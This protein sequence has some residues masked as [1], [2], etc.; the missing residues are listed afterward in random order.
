MYIEP[1]TTI[2]LYSGIPFDNTYEHTLWFDDVTAQNTYFHGGTHPGRAKYTLANNSYQR[3]ERGKMRIEKC[4]DDIYDCNYLAFQNTNYG[5]KWFYAFIIS[6]EYIN[7]VTSEIVFEIDVMQTYLFDMTLEECFVER[8]HSETDEI[9]DNILPEPIDTSNVICSFYSQTM[10]MQKY[11]LIINVSRYK[12]GSQYYN[13]GMVN[14]LMQGMTPRRFPLDGDTPAQTA[15]NIS[16]I[17][18][19]LDELIDD[20]HQ[21]EVISMCMFPT[22]YTGNYPFYPAEVTIPDILIP[23]S[24][25]QGE[26]E[27]KNKKLLTFP[28]SY[29][30]VDSLSDH[31]VYR[32]E[33]FKEKTNT[34]GRYV[35]FLTIG[36]TSAQPQITLIPQDYNGDPVGDYNM[37]EKLVMDDFPQVGWSADSFKIWAATHGGSTAIKTV[38]G[39]VSATAG[40]VGLWTALGAGASATGYGAPLVALIGGILALANVGNEVAVAHSMPAQER[41]TNSGDIDVATRRKDFYFRRMQITP[42]QARVVDDFFSMFGYACNRVKIPNRKAR[43]LWNY[44]KTKGCNILGTAPADDIRK[45]AKIYD[46]GITFWN[47]PLGFGQYHNADGTLIDNPPVV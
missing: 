33:W 3:V 1:N 41:G 15:Q 31:A 37:T 46:H 27:P 22:F 4:A 7:N 11:D 5:N 45:V 13:G 16:D 24:F 34:N 8:E 25:G 17:L 18:S 6:V 23:T 40:A 47:S 21:D 44:V 19:Y 38:G 9:G 28:Y 30:D 2:K 20:N 26:Y 39:T 14:G 32:Y 29:L 43:Q 42:Q 35:H 36:T 10:N 12:E